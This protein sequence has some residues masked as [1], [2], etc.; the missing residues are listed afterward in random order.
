[1]EEYCVRIR[2]RNGRRCL[3]EYPPDAEGRSAAEPVVVA[4][5]VDAAAAILAAALVSEAV[6]VA[7]DQAVE[8]V[9][10]WAAAAPAEG[11]VEAEVDSQEANVV[12]EQG[13]TTMM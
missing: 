7:V 5:V 9:S 2:P 11:S 6:V 1:M 13:E 8:A 4:W 10:G 3:Q 12:T